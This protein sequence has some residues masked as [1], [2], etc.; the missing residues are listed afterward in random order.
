MTRPLILLTNDD[1][2]NSPGLAALAAALD[3]LGDLL[4][5][6]PQVQQSG[7]GRSFP[8]SNDGRMFETTIHANGQAWKAYGVSASP[9]QAVLHGVLELADRPITLAASGINY[10]ENVG[11]GITASGTVGAA[12]EAAANHIPTLAISLQVPDEAQHMNNDA[13][14]DFTGA[15]YWSRFFAERLLHTGRIEDADVL[16]IDLPGGATPQTPWQITRLQIGNYFLHLPPLRRRLED[17]GR[18]GYAF[19]PE[20]IY[21]DNSDA[22]AVLDGVI[23]VTPLTLDIT[24][25]IAPDVLRRA[26]EPAQESVPHNA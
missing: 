3:P 24:A 20:A 17:E 8:Q 2:V 12:L 11:T 26:L 25:R 18:I 16:K 7:M 5:V 6:A 13:G 19:N 4:I 1:G 14:V 9:A 22:K 10:G 15:I 21:E 23:S